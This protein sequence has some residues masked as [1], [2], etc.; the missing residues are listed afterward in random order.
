MLKSTSPHAD[1]RLLSTNHLQLLG[2]HDAVN[3]NGG[4][5]GGQRWVISATS[6]VPSS[7]TLT[8]ARFIE[9]RRSSY[10]WCSYGGERKKP[11]LKKASQHHNSQTLINTIISTFTDIQELLDAFLCQKSKFTPKFTL[12]IINYDTYSWLTLFFDI[13]VFCNLFITMSKSLR[14]FQEKHLLV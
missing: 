11:G 5:Y 12:S 4:G 14:R 1:L 8:S 10:S 13:N 6:L 2:G 9:T 3:V 7:Q